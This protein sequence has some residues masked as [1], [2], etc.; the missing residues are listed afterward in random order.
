M[1]LFVIL[2]V[3]SVE[4]VQLVTGTDVDLQGA[5]S[6]AARAAAMQVDGA[7]QAAGDPRIG[8]DR[9]HLAFRQVLAS[10]LGL[11]P[12]TLAPLPGSGVEGVADYV[13]V[14]YNV[15][16]AY[17]AGGIP[18]GYVYSFSGGAYPLTES[19]VS[20]TF[21]ISAA[22]ISLDGSGERTVKLASPGVVALVR[23]GIRP[24]LAA[25]GSEAVRWAAARIVKR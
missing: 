12:D 25:D 8:P 7:S 21:G 22:G 1:P 18:A 9:A 23:A 13:L 6:E 10:N 3:A 4:Q 17:A 5:L 15:D 11:S 19:Q 14:V 2:M 20:G 16:D 24:V